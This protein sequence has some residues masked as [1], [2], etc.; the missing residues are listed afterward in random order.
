[1]VTTRSHAREERRQD[2][3]YV[4]R[5]TPSK[6]DPTASR[7]SSDAHAT[8]LIIGAAIL[9][10]L[11]VGLHPYSGRVFLGQKRMHIASYTVWSARVP[12]PSLW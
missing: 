11:L 9:L 6:S 3:G 4:K 12:M 8:A 7:Q 2:V 5:S 1:M 10:R